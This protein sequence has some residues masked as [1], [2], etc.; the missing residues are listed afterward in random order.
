MESIRW[1]V[2]K[3]GDEM[4]RQEFVERWKHQLAGMILDGATVART[5]ADLGLWCRSVMGKTDVLLAR[6]Y[7]DLHP[8]EAIKPPA[9]SSNGVASTQVRK[10]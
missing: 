8:A 6:M 2:S 4:T 10:V 7:D 1:N 5:G 9:P 3:A